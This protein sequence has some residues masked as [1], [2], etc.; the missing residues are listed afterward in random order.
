MFCRVLK[1]TRILLTIN[2]CVFI[3]WCFLL[4]SKQSSL[5]NDKGIASKH[6]SV[7]LHKLEI[8]AEKMKK[9][10]K[11]QYPAASSNID[12]YFDKG[13]PT[14]YAITPTYARLTQKAD[15]T[16]LLYTLLH[17]PN[18]HWIVVEDSDEKTALVTNFLKSAGLSYTHLN[19]KTDVNFKLKPNDPNWLMPRGVEQRNIGLAWIRNNVAQSQLGVVYFMDDDN[20]YSL[21]VFEEMRYTKRGSVWPVGLSGGLKFEGPGTCKN[22]KVL[23]W[24][25][26]W[27]PDRPFPLDMAGFA[28]NIKLIFSYPE[29]KYSNL[30]PRG[31]LESHFLTAVGLSRQDVEA[32]AD[33]CTKILVWHTRTEKP[34]LKQEMKLIKAGKPSNPLMEV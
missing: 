5:S 2:V 4:L 17:V 24:Y 10:L 31:H 16:R 23:T 18:F 9:S 34:V 25:T 19:V 11:N 21:K 20:T 13:I 22:G 14:I 30:V 32:K 26:L 1:N 27:Q 3:F 29:A 28:V 8:Y 12:F 33:D 7:G 6:A 15:L